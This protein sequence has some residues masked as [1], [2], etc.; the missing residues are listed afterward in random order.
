MVNQY[1]Y[2]FQVKLPNGSTEKIV[3]TSTSP[4]NATAM[5]RSQYGER[6]IVTGPHK[7]RD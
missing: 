1:R 5:I 3:I 4:Q 2:E 7:L 6:S